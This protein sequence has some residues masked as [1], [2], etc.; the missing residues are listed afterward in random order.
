MYT[1]YLYTQGRRE[2]E[3]VEPERRGEELHRRV[4]IPKLG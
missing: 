2:G 1:V 3:R 4:Q